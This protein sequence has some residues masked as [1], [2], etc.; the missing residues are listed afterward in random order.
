MPQMT[1]LDL[2]HHAA[3]LRPDLPVLLYSGNVEGMDDDALRRAGVRARLDKPVDP[4]R[5]HSLL[6]QWL[7]KTT[8]A[9]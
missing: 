9:S 2:A 8:P 1:G 5:L 4:A 3:V 6:R 7:Q